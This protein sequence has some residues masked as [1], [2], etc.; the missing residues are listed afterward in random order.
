MLGHT[1]QDV[2]GDPVALVLAR[3]DLAPDTV[4]IG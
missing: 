3:D 4:G 2:V 1:M